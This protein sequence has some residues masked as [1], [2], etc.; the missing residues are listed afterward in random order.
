VLAVMPIA[1]VVLRALPDA[2]HVFVGFGHVCFPPAADG[3]YPCRQG[4]RSPIVT[5]SHGPLTNASRPPP[6]RI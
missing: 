4:A 5:A 1:G 3:T 2:G 6:Y